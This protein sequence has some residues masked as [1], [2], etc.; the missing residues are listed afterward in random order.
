MCDYR[1]NDN[2]PSGSLIDRNETVALQ[3]TLSRVVRTTPREH[4]QEPAGEGGHKATSGTGGSRGTRYY[5][6]MRTPLER[7][8]DEYLSLPMRRRFI[9]DRRA[10]LDSIK[11]VSGHLLAGAR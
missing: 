8:V 3:S 9:P 1:Y 7:A 6:R 2:L 5:D 11:A 4:Y 10:A